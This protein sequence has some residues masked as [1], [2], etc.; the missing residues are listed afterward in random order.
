MF[1]PMVLKSGIKGTMQ[2]F[3]FIP[4]GLI[5]CAGSA[6]LVESPGVIALMEQW[7]KYNLEHQEITGWRIQ[8]LATVD[9]RQ[10]E[11]VKRKFEQLY[12]EFPLH[13]HHNE[14]Y[15]HLRAGAFLSLQ[16]AQAFLKQ[17]QSEYPAAIPVT[18]KI[19]VEELLLY[20]Q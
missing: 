19:K 5:P 20:D 12:P 7:K 13:F 15:F 9:R 14:P 10:M 2:V 11:T 17:M 16:R 18:D 8:I 1:T 3:V 6:Q 4:F